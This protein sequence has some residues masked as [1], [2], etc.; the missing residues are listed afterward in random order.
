MLAERVP[1]DAE[2]NMEKQESPSFLNS[3][4]D[5]KAKSTDYSIQK[6]WALVL[7]SQLLALRSLRT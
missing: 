2:I 4:R 6:V 5:M 1:D 7:L 3:D